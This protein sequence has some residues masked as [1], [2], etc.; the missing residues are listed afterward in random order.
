L[1]IESLIEKMAVA[2]LPGRVEEAHFVLFLPHQ[3]GGGLLLVLHLVGEGT[4]ADV[5]QDHLLLLFY[6]HLAAKIDVV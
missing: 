3:A 2:L 1:L 6:L 4:V 5:P